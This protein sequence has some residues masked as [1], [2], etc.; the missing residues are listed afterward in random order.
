VESERLIRS[1]E[2][3]EYLFTVVDIRDNVAAIRR[4]LEED[5]DGWEA[6]EDA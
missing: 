4:L 5:D 3:T 6:Q 2:L 1:D